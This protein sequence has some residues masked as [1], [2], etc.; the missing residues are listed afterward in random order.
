LA[1]PT[2]AAFS[3][4]AGLKSEKENARE[5]TIGTKYST[6]KPKSQGAI[7]R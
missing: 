2:K 6:M 7:K 5:A 3:G 4:V 1:N